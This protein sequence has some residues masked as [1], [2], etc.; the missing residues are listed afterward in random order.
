MAYSIRLKNLVVRMPKVGA[1]ALP[2]G[3]AVAVLLF[4][5][6]PAAAQKPNVPDTPG[7]S[8]QPA[9]SR[10]IP[11]NLGE[12]LV[13][14][15]EDLRRLEMASPVWIDKKRKQV[16]LIGTTCKADYPL[17]FFATYPERGYE[18]VVV[19]YTP[20]SVV[21]AALLALGAKPGK[22]VQYQP[23]FVP[24]KGTEVEIDVC[25]KDKHGKRQK[26][27]AQQ[28]IRDIKTKQPLDVN[29]V[30]AGSVFW[31]DA[32]TG[33]KS[34]L[35]DRGDFITV[36]NVPTALLDV[37]IESASA[38]ESRMFEGFAERLPPPGT[39]VT[40]ILKPKLDRAEK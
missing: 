3:V 17:E 21:H 35:A 10:E 9:Y 4:C 26:T 13:D 36:L 40:L 38:L 23:T 1:L 39:P 28:W 25:W 8:A 18:S 11:P 12:P 27:P 2:F 14:A 22:P 24:P 34:Y 7:Q 33:R 30:F 6:S 31:G 20:P 37:P 19:I 15:P 5:G 16:V 32:A 29:W